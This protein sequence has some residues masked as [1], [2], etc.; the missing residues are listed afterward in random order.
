MLLAQLQLKDTPGQGQEWVLSFPD[1]VG[2]W[3]D[4]ELK[5]ICRVNRDTFVYLCS[6]LRPMLGRRY[7]IGKP[8]S[9]EQCVAI[10]LWRLGTNAEYRTTFLK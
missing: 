9:V 8:I 10:T 4:I 2:T 5:Q 3:D 7:A 6:D 1:I